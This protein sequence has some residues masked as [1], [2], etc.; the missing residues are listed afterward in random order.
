MRKELI[1]KKEL[2]QMKPNELNVQQTLISQ[3][4]SVSLDEVSQYVDIIKNKA[5][6][7]AEFRMP[8]PQIN[9]DL[10]TITDTFTQAVCNTYRVEIK[11]LLKTIPTKVL[12]QIN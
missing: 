8:V 9:K 4:L 2:M 5:F 1:T 12:T 3:D 10:I 11:T 6:A 7:D